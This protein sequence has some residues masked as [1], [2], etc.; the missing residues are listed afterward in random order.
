MHLCVRVS[1]EPQQREMKDAKVSL[2]LQLQLNKCS[3]ASGSATDSQLSSPPSE[4]GYGESK[5]RSASE[6]SVV[7]ARWFEFPLDLLLPL[8]TGCRLSSTLQVQIM[9]L[10]TA[11]RWEAANHCTASS[12]ANPRV[13]EWDKHAFHLFTS[14]L[15]NCGVLTHNQLIVVFF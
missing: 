15:S 3:F 2:Y 9:Q 8:S 1:F 10:F 13:L 4:L 12:G 6:P 11:P 14:C 5:N 7:G